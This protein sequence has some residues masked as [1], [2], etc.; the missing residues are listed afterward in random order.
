MRERFSISGT[1]STKRHFM[2]FR[3]NYGRQ[4]KFFFEEWNEKGD[5]LSESRI[6][7]VCGVRNWRSGYPMD[8]AERRNTNREVEDDRITCPGIFNFQFIL[9]FRGVIFLHVI[10][11]I[12]YKIVSC[13]FET[14]FLIVHRLYDR[15]WTKNFV[16]ILI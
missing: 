9:M 7:A 3:W 11:W 2:K 13:L 1:I 8:E 5:W 16:Y 10:R 15:Y 4:P 12:I 14:V 6:L